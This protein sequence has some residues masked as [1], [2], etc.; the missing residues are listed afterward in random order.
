MSILSPAR[1]YGKMVKQAHETFNSTNKTHPSAN[2]KSIIAFCAIRATT[3]MPAA[4][5]LKMFCDDV[6]INPDRVQDWI[7]AGYHLK[8]HEAVMDEEAVLACTRLRRALTQFKTHDLGRM[9]RNDLTWLMH[10][11]EFLSDTINDH[12]TSLEQARSHP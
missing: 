12:L 10:A 11:S 2:S 4:F 3:N 5:T 6:G 7:D 1:L 8:T 9:G